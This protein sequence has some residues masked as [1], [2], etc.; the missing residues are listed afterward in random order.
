[1]SDYRIIAHRPISATRF[2]S[3]MGGKGGIGDP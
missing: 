1:M 2:M 3:I